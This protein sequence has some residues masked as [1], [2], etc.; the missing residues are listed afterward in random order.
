T[1]MIFVLS[2]GYLQRKGVIFE[3]NGG[4]SKR[5]CVIFIYM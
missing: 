2:G 3:I 5:K 1:G 4:F